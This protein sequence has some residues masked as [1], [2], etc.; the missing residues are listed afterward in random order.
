MHET[1]ER[2]WRFREALLHRD[3]PT[4]VSE[5]VLTDLLG[6]LGAD[7]LRVFAA[8]GRETILTI[9]RRDAEEAASLGFTGTPKFIVNGMLVSG[10]YPVEHFMDVISVWRE[11]AS[12]S[13][14]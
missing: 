5:E 2:A 9:I 7:P 8:A 10:S 12:L 13:R 14:L 6:A 11:E 4:P 3:G 1:P